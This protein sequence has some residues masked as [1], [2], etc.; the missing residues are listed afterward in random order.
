MTFLQKSVKSLEEKLLDHAQSLAR[1][2]TGTNNKRQIRKERNKRRRKKCND[3]KKRVETES[4]QKFQL[5]NQFNQAVNYFRKGFS[6]SEWKYIQPFLPPEVVTAI[7]DCLQIASRCVKPFVSLIKFKDKEQKLFNGNGE[8]LQLAAD[9]IG[10]LEQSLSILTKYVSCYLKIH[11]PIQCY[12]NLRTNRTSRPSQIYLKGSMFLDEDHIHLVKFFYGN[13]NNDILHM[14]QQQV[15]CPKRE[16]KLKLDQR[17]SWKNRPCIE[18]YIQNRYFHGTNNT[19]LKVEYQRSKVSKS[20]IIVDD[21]FIWSSTQWEHLSG[22]VFEDEYSDNIGWLNK[23]NVTSLEKIIS[24]VSIALCYDWFVLNS[25]DEKLNSTNHRKVVPLW[26]FK[27]SFNLREK[28]D[29][30]KI[31]VKHKDYWH[32]KDITINWQACGSIK[33]KFHEQIKLNKRHKHSQK[34]QDLCALTRENRKL[35]PPLVGV[36]LEN[37][38]E[39]AN[40]VSIRKEVNKTGNQ[41]VDEEKKPLRS[42][43]F[44]L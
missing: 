35:I 33:K 32:F 40:T 10:L 12:E 26:S 34:L 6:A 43:C 28:I 1:L 9:Y 22:W 27:E 20:V 17:N 8:V 7:T 29:Y 42:P 3:D 15:L 16:W 30:L 11:K 5:I 14:R 25:M 19:Y 31:L 2:G 4:L 44:I 37:I 13:L 38:L 36:N 23:F 18:V 41:L 39:D 24:S 21:N